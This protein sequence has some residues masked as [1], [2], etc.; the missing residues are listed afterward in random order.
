MLSTNRFRSTS[1]P[2]ADKVRALSRI[3][4]ADAMSLVAMLFVTVT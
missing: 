3:K 4:S 2:C 1:E